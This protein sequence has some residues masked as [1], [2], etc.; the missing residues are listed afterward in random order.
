MSIQQSASGEWLQFKGAIKE[1]W[2]KL[3]NDDLTA[4]NGSREKLV[5]KLVSAYSMADDEAEREVDRFW[6][7]TER[8][9]RHTQQ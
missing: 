2:G 3:T 6:T 9:I 7:D 5:G 1:K 4:I 8:Q